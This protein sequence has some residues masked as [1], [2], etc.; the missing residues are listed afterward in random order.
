MP[1]IRNWPYQ[2]G[3]TFSTW[4]RIDPVS[5][6]NIE[7]EKPY[8]YWFCTSKGI[9]YRA[10]F[11]GSCLVLTYSRQAGKEQQHC[12]QYEFKP[13]EW[14]M[15]T[16]SH[17]YNRW[18]KSMVNCFI[19]GKLF[20]QTAIQFYIDPN[21]VF[22]KCI[23][24]A[25]P[26]SQNEL[27]Q[28]SGQL[29]TLYLF[30]Q[31]LDS[32]IVE[33]LFMLGPSYK[34]Q[35]R[36]ENECSHLQLKS[37]Y[38]K[39]LYD[40]KL[41]Q[42]I[43]FMYNPTNCDSQ[44]LLQSSPKLQLETTTP[45]SQP[46]YFIH[47]SHALMLTDVKAIKTSSI[48]T[49]LLSIGGIQVFYVLFGQ[50][51]CKQPDDSIDYSV[52]S[53]LFQILCDMIELSHNIQLQ[54]I[55]T[56]GFLAMSYMLEKA[57]RQHITD[58]VLNSILYL[59]KFFVRLDNSNGS[60]LL[61]QLLDHI[62]FNPSIWIYCSIE[63][64]TKLYSYLATEFV[65]DLQ[66]YANI[67]RISAVIQTMHALKYYY[68][69]IDPEN[70]SGF[71]AKAI[72]SQRPSLEQISSLRNYMI[73]FVKELV[74][75]ENGVQDDEL[76]AILNYLHTVHED[77]NLIDVLQLVVT[78]MNEHPPSMIP[79]FDRKL[80]IRTIFKLLASNSETIRIKTLKLLGF[81]LQKST[82]KR[83]AETMSVFNLFSLLTDR[84]LLHQNSFSMAVYNTLYEI[85]VERTIQQIVDDR[86]QD[87]DQ[88][89]RIENP[90]ILKVIA[91]LIRNDSSKNMKI[92]SI[93]KQF[94]NDLINLCK[95]NR[96]NRRILLQIS[97]WQEFLIGLAYINPQDDD[98]NEITNY[99]FDL[100][101][102]LLNHAIKYE[103]G[104]WRVWIDTLS[105][106]HSRVSREEYQTKMNR[107]YDEHE[108]TNGE[109][110]QLPPFRTPE[111][112]WS[113]IH[114][115][116]LGDILDEI[117]SEIDSWKSNGVK[118]LVDQVNNVDNNIFC[119]NTIHIIT[120]MGDV[121]TNS[122]GGLLPLLASATS[123]NSSDIEILENTEGLS[124]QEGDE[125][126]ERIM[127]IVDL[128]VL[129][130]SLNFN[131]LEQE[132]NM[133]NGAI[134]RQTLRLTF[135]FAV[136]NCLKS[137][138]KINSSKSEPFIGIPYKYQDFLDKIKAIN[139]R[140]PIEALLEHHLNK[141]ND[142][143]SNEFL[144][145]SIDIY[146]LRSLVYRDVVRN[147]KNKAKPIVSVVRHCFKYLLL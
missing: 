55:N 18:S 80:G 81:F 106:I 12:I 53:T 94:L 67:R 105:I 45:S 71:K 133:P 126:L 64:Q 7:K 107:L 95:E 35:F 38:L 29:S 142:D 16:I 68:F 32:S 65:N 4:F 36:Y 123:N 135:T 147:E 33:A 125:I 24:G 139:Q 56:K 96:E 127:R 122:C 97:V 14:Y 21:E 117:E 63:V 13:R 75:K 43:V 28:F 22:D 25:T 73:L 138:K 113:L 72:D 31:S 78:L 101:R 30:D 1:P 90:Q 47:N 57:S 91:T 108:K 52:C 132:K 99:V 115:R 89:H 118:S 140:D 144:L 62:V 58:K 128:L 42:S 102:I 114:K 141:Q 6:T 98:E 46:Q 51:D 69:M 134:I 41:T 77:E 87:P 93:K 145:K 103:Y 109:P 86:H 26:D 50:L 130:N 131:D 70:R 100:F 44:L 48:F 76:Q 116:L 23:L 92:I 137:R 59:T 20:S 40:G 17:I 10:H 5:G 54:M 104:G 112:K 84:L 66:I 136:K 143:S 85:L 61:K 60:I 120:Q 121:L 129:A 110:M 37:N 146:R 2:N 111:F 3:F 39:L 49:S 15:I 88:T 9:G 11:M 27:T 82:S 19:N 124:L 34:N 74:T 8:L 79:S 119:L 83:K